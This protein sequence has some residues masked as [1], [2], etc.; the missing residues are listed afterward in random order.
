MIP[1]SSL[2]PTQRIDV[3]SDTLQ[4]LFEAVGLQ[5]LLRFINPSEVG[6]ALREKVVLEAARPETLLGQ[7]VSTV[8]EFLHDQKMVFSNFKIDLKVD[9]NQHSTLT[10]EALG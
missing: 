8:I 2:N 5:V 1:G 10:V 4:E 7:W 3:H 9:A 6:E